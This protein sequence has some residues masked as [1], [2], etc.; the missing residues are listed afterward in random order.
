MT[1]TPGTRLGPYEILSLLGAGGMG[2]VYRARDTRLGRDVAVKTIP[3]ALAADPRHAQ[4]FELEARAAGSLNHPNVVSIF[5]VGSH[6]GTQ[7]VVMELAEGRTLREHLTDGPLPIGRALEI[8]MQCA[9]ALDAAHAKGIVH[10]DLK[11]ANL[12]IGPGGRVKV[13]DFGLAKVVGRESPGAPRAAG[14]A[15]STASGTIAGTVPYMAPEQLR[16]EPVDTRADLFAL[17][18]VLYEM[19][20]GR[21][22]FTGATP[23][24]IASAILRDTPLSARALRADL[25]MEVDQVI[26]RAL[27]KSPADRFETASEMRRALALAESGLES[28][29]GAR[30]PSETGLAAFGEPFRRAASGAT[31]VPSIAVLPFVNRSQEEGDEYFSDG[32]A[33]ELLNVLAK[34]QGLRVVGRTSSYQF[35]GVNADLRVIGKRLNVAA[36]VEGSVRKTG[37]RVRISV[38]LVKVADGFHLW[39]ESYDRTLDDIF[40]VQD[41][42]AQSVVKELRTTLLGEAPDSKAGEAAKA[43][44]AI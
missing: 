21:L 44:V 15:W 26:E 17:G 16:G 29:L 37:N 32:L 10:R 35:K 28:A 11:P 12:M 2:E 19:A 31:V 4:R 23:A 39:S 1:L 33:D 20:T 30:P 5:D 42:I 43:D 40:A 8:A 3:R 27:E 38:Q 25:P 34:I 22:P 13:L 18:V 36:L 41:D 24:D 6:E 9:E 14:A 7:F